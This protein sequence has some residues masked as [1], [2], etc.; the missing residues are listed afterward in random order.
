LDLNSFRL[1]ANSH[2]VETTID[3]NSRELTFTFD[4][5]Y[6]PDSFINEPGSHGLVK[7][8]IL[9]NDNL[10]SFIPIQNTANIFFDANPPIITNT[11][12]NTFTDVIP[13]VFFGK[14]LLEGAYESEG[15]MSTNL[16][17][18]IP[19]SQPYNLA[20]YN[21]S[22]GETLTSIPENMVDWVLVEAR[23]GTPSTSGLQGTQLLERQAGI[24]LNNGDILNVDG[25]SG[26]RFVNLENEQNYHFLIRHRN[27]LDVISALPLT[28][29]LEMTLDFTTNT[30]TAFGPEQMKAAVDGTALLHSGDV[31]G[32]GL[33]QV[34][35]YDLWFNNNA[36]LNTYLNT[37]FNL[38]GLIQTTDYDAWF[39]N[40][41]KVGVVEVQF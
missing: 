15:M 33:I 35:D 23:T 2:A 18:L 5:I 27:H 4:N 3:G 21:Y 1:I 7:F 16:N 20:P 36:V 9:T 32:D 13:S 41:A 24:L 30:N 29:D 12:S 39:L 37:D 6:L 22:G 34:S 17:N 31:N 26:I 38:D 8:R 28:A 10:S 14:I 40:K 25:T 19:L 11:V